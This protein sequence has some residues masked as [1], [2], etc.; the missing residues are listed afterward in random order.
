MLINESASGRFVVA[1]DFSGSENVTLVR[2]KDAH[3]RSAA[4]VAACVETL[5]DSPPL[6]RAAEGV[7]AGGFDGERVASFESAPACVAALHEKIGEEDAARCAASA[8]RLLLV[9]C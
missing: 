1:L 6:K 7:R 4:E 8:R 5:G 3:G 9:L 2:L